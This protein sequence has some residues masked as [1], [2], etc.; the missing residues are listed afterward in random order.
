MT[1]PDKSKV[2]ARWTTHI[3]GNV[4]F[5]AIAVSKKSHTALNYK[6]YN[7]LGTPASAGCI[8]MTVADAKWIYDNIKTGTK[9]KII[10][11]SKNTPGPLGKPATI[12]IKSSK[13]KYDPT[14][15]AISDS[16]KQ[17]DYKECRITGYMKKN[18]TK[19]GY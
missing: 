11:G 16:T 7:K 12:R 14:D 2:Y 15:P 19:V 8:R 3:V 5:H 9:V 10:K 18:G 4:Y 13:V 1:E 6:T 17:K